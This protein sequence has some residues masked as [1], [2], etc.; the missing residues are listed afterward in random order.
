MQIKR[1]SERNK[2]KPAQEQGMFR[3][4]EVRRVDGSDLPGGKHHGCRYYVLDL[5]H[6]QYAAAAMRAYAAA[7]RATHP[8]LAADI[9]AEFGAATP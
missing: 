9:E 4:F 2:A 6:D 5:T 7:C 3:K 1:L 8:D